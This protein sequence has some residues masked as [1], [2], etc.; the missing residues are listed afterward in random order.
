M[1]SIL[2]QRLSRFVGG[3]PA[4]SEAGAPIQE[5]GAHWWR[6]T[7]EGPIRYDREIAACIAAGYQRA[8]PFSERFTL[9]DSDFA[10]DYERSIA[11]QLGPDGEVLSE[12][13][14]GRDDD[15]VDAGSEH[16]ASC[17]A[18]SLTDDELAE[19]QANSIRAAAPEAAVPSAIGETRVGKRRRERSDADCSALVGGDMPIL[20]G[21]SHMTV[22]EEKRRRGERTQSVPLSSHAL[23]IPTAQ[24]PPIRPPAPVIRLDSE[25]SEPD[26]YGQSESWHGA[27]GRCVFGPSAS[28]PSA[29]GPSLPRRGDEKAYGKR[30]WLRD[31]PV[32]FSLE[33]LTAD[34][35][36]HAVETSGSGYNVTRGKSNQTAQSG[37]A[38][39]GRAQPS[40]AHSDIAHSDT[41][42]SDTAHSD[43]TLILLTL[44]LLTLI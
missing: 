12:L 22:N 27:S 38:R 13:P 40:T 35:G 33:E 28:G 26:A 43:I 16:P 23:P 39:P 5:H 9:D 42:H 36:L 2:R 20:E 25:T 11:L 8:T 10:I 14:V 21:C 4:S 30:A 41:A 1:L 18:L 24:R 7:P 31:A 29:S 32:Y 44:I 34:L 19:M 3:E 15:R 6:I 17:P 37:T